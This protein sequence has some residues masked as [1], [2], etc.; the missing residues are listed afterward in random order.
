MIKYKKKLKSSENAH[1]YQIKVLER[2]TLKS[3]LPGAIMVR[4]LLG[5]YIGDS[6]R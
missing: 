2:K 6:I 4:F 1:A 5:K 3:T